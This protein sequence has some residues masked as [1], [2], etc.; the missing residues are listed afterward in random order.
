MCRV[1]CCPQ[2]CG[3]RYWGVSRQ[4]PTQRNAMLV[5]TKNPD[6]KRKADSW[7]WCAFCFEKFV[8]YCCRRTSLC[9]LCREMRRLSSRYFP[10][11]QMS[12]TRWNCQHDEINFGKLVVEPKSPMR[13]RSDYGSSA[14]P[15][16]QTV[17]P[18]RLAHLKTAPYFGANKLL[19]RNQCD[20]FSF[21]ISHT[22]ERS[23]SRSFRSNPPLWDVMQDVYSTDP[24]QKTCSRPCRIFG[25]LPA[26]WARSYQASN[27]SA[28]D[29]LDDGSENRWSVRWFVQYW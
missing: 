6:A 23:R 1:F 20:I 21:A 14:K 17:S 22:S 18:C 26:T 27:L 29:D 4:S 16:K 13:G 5:K 25:S 11:G 19:G 12:P 10:L 24:T 15:R 28:P 8:S 9:V 2:E 7:L 3:Y